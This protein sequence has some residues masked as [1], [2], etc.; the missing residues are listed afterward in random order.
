MRIFA[1]IVE[2]PRC[3]SRRWS[4]AR[5]SQGA[6][7]PTSS[8]S[9][10]CPTRRSRIW[11][12]R[13]RRSSRRGLR[14]QRR[15][16]RCR[17][18]AARR[19]GGGRLSVEPRP[20]RR[21]D[22]HRG[23]AARAGADPRPHG[24][25][26]SLAARHRAAN[27]ARAAPPR[28]SDPRSHPFRLHGVARPLR[29]SCG[30]CLP[31]AEILMGTGNL[32]ELTDADSAGVTA[33]LLGICSELQHPQ[34]ADRAGEPAHAAHGRGARRGAAHHVRAREDDSLPKG[35]GGGL[36]SLHDR[37]PFPR[38]P[39]RSR[40]PRAAVRDRNFRIEVARGR[41]PCLQLATATTSPATPSQLFDKLGVET[42]RRARVLSRR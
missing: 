39:S 30:A 12:R 40:R 7:A 35:Y 14:G 5:R 38:R 17:G 9:A 42:R 4:R 21:F 1:E 13:C 32:T 36:L 15:F 26:A 31:D 3:R 6:R 37:A 22:R 25:L 24:D 33:V 41:H 29:A 34:R 23:D 19:R 18:A 27:G 10:A 8:I 28:R 2:A 20:R 16:R 11:R